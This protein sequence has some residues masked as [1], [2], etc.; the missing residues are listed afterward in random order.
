MKIVKLPILKE[1]QLEAANNI[2]K[3]LNQNNLVI[4]SG[5]MGEVSIMN[6]QGKESMDIIFDKNESTL[7]ESKDIEEEN[8]ESEEY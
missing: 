2:I 3:L 4:S 6:R 5:Y 8:E 7:I 1:G